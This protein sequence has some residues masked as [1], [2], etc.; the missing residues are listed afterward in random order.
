MI[1]IRNLLLSAAVE[2]IQSGRASPK[3]NKYLSTIAKKGNVNVNLGENGRDEGGRHK[4]G[5]ERE[6]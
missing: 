2:S 3:V 4:S 6:E 5:V 1:Q